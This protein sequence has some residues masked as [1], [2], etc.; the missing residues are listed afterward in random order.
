MKCNFCGKYH[1]INKCGICDK[2]SLYCPCYGCLTKQKQDLQKIMPF[3]K[4]LT[5]KINMQ[6]EGV[7]MQKWKK[8]FPN[9]HGWLM[10]NGFRYDKTKDK[11]I[12]LNDRRRK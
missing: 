1:P 6:S 11:S 2:E 3:Y 7:S 9:F 5:D 10:D 12:Q 4:I 8:A